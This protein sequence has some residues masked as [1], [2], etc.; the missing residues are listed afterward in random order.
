MAMKVAVVY[1]SRTGNT[2]RAAT[3]VGTAIEDRGHD[4]SIQSVDAL[5]YKFLADA[6]LIVFGTWVAGHFIV[7]QKPGDARRLA[8]V[9]KLTGK[10]VALFL[11]YAINPGNA[12]RKFE[13]ALTA[14][15]AEVIGGYA[16]NRSK[17]PAGVEDFVEA[18]LESAS[19][20]TPA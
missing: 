4:V 19:H 10:R 18:V 1:A 9:P 5:D 16:W 12:L 15:G 8:R 13:K 17:L 6:D 20:P 11:T 7:G 14:E 2:A 3:L